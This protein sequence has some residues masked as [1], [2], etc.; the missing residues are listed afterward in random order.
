VNLSRQAIYLL[1]LAGVCSAENPSYSNRG[2]WNQDSTYSGNHSTLQGDTVSHHSFNEKQMW[3]W[4]KYYA[5]GE[6]LQPGVEAVESSKNPWILINSLSARETGTPA[7]PVEYWRGWNDDVE[8]I[9]EG[10]AVVTTWRDGAEGAYTMMHEDF[11]L[12]PYEY[13]VKPALEIARDFPEIKQSWGAVVAKMNDSDFERAVAMVAEGHEIFNHSYEHTSPNDQ[14][15][16]F[17]PS[18]TIPTYDPAIPEEIRGLTVSGTWG[19]PDHV[20]V[21]PAPTVITLEN[22]LVSISC[23]PHWTQNAP[24]PESVG[25]LVSIE[26]KQIEVIEPIVTAK[27]ETEKIVLSTEQDQ[28]VKYS[29][30]DSSGNGMNEGLIAATG[31]TWLETT[32]LDQYGENGWSG[33]SPNVVVDN[34]SPVFIVKVHC[35][36]A[37]EE[38]EYKLNIKEAAD[39]INE[40][41][42]DKFTTIGEYFSQGKKVEFY[43]YPFSMNSEAML[44]TLDLYGYVGTSGETRTGSVTPGDFYHPFRISSDIFYISQSDWNPSSKG[45]QYVFPNN[46]HSRIGLNE[47]VDEIIESKGYMIR[48][49]S[50]VANIAGDEWYDTDLPAVQWPI[51]SPAY[52]KGGWHGGIT[53]N[54]LI[55]HYTYLKSKIDAHE[56][57]VYT[58]SEAVKYRM[59]AN[60]CSGASLIHNGDTY[61]LEIETI[62]TI[63]EKYHDEITVIIALNEAVDF[64]KVE[65]MYPD[66]NHSSHPRISPRQMDTEGK[67]WAISM[68]PY[69]GAAELALNETHPEK[70]VS[71]DM[72]TPVVENKLETAGIASFQG[73]RNGQIYLNLSKG[74]YNASVYSVSGRELLNIELV[75]NDGVV[76][77][78]IAAELSSAGM[79]I[80]EITQKGASVISTKFILD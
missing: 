16:Y 46:P 44:D 68:N 53:T 70:A 41:I 4:T 18:Q 7:T 1:A 69:L 3:W 80:L 48:K 42:Y 2:V 27:A 67:I 61:I 63:P 15:Q 66:V 30:R 56:L 39:V 20:P 62:D 23:T 33:T 26:G 32:E 17:Y 22:E 59:T 71:F 64:L 47:M 77:A 72:V 11:G 35:I 25:S 31:V 12:M 14:W 5:K 10:E 24:T 37:W 36:T 52:G 79:Y 8:Y 9:K 6:Q 19:D 29:V 65:Y 40:R 73:L 28:F 60:A 45:E 51:N 74:T 38:E 34:G 57:V 75:S 58:P 50:A 54:H 13:S 49:L 76:T 55:D 21:T 78:D 43:D